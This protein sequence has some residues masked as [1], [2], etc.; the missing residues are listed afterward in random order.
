MPLPVE[1][2]LARSR[3]SFLLGSRSCLARAT[4]AEFV[5]FTDFPTSVQRGQYATI[6][7]NFADGNCYTWTAVVRCS[8]TVVVAACICA[9]LLTCLLASAD[10][11]GRLRAAAE[12]QRGRAHAALEPVRL[13]RHIRIAPLR[14]AVS[15]RLDRS[16]AAP[17]T[18]SATW[19]MRMTCLDTTNVSA[20][21]A[22]RLVARHRSLSAAH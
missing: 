17:T 3:R 13:V 14:A 20:V 18:R 9:Q 11:A 8:L 21:H 4:A 10:L 19:P 2:T 6:S 16:L 12:E 15:Q 5:T 22:E 1:R 7:F